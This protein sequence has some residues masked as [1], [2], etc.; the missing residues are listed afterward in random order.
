[1]GKFQHYL[2]VALRSLKKHKVSSALSLLGLSAAFALSVVVGLMTWSA[3]SSDNHWKNADNIYNINRIKINKDGRPMVYAMPN[4]L[5]ED[6]KSF[7]SDIIYATSPFFMQAEL[8][9]ENKYQRLSGYKVDE[10]FFKIF[11]YKII[12]GNIQSIFKVPNGIALSEMKAI[13]L[14]GKQ[15]PIGQSVEL[16]YR[17]EPKLFSIQSIFKKPSGWS[18]MR[19][20]DAFVASPEDVS[21][22]FYAWV[23]IL[24]KE[25]AELENLIPR[26]TKHVEEKYPPKEWEKATHFAKFKL[27]GASFYGVFSW[28]YRERQIGLMISAAT[29][30]LVALLN[31]MALTTA[32]TATRGKDVALRKIMGA[33]RGELS[34]Q[35]VVES[36]LLVSFAYLLG[37]AFAE[38]I[39]G[40]IGALIGNEF[41]VV[42][43]EHGFPLLVGWALAL[44][45]GLLTSTYPI[46]AL[47]RGKASDLLANFQRNL[48][49]GGTRL[50]SLL[51]ILQT[52]CGLGL[53]LGS[54][55]IYLQTNHAEYADKGFEQEGLLYISAPRNQKDM[56]SA[57]PM[58]NALA[59]VEGIKGLSVASSPPPFRGSLWER[60]IV[61]PSTAEHVEIKYG[62]IGDNFMQLLRV[63]I[64]AGRIPPAVESLEKGDEPLSETRILVNEMF[65]EE[66]FPNISNEEVLDRCVFYIGR[67]DKQ[68]DTCNKITAV[69]ANYHQDSGEQALAATIFFPQKSK[70]TN[71]IMVRYDPTQGKNLL[72]KVQA[73]WDEY[74]PF[75]TFNYDFVDDL[76]EKGFIQQRATASLLLFTAIASLVLTVAGLY[77]MAKF[78][79]ARR[80][81]EIA[82]R[83]VLGASSGDIVKLVV[84]QL[85][86]P[87]IVGALI[88][89]PIGWYYAMDWLSAYSIRIE[90]EPWH[91]VLLGIFG[92]AFFLITA[93]GEILRAMR[94]RPA[95]VLHYE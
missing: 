15:D 57:G 55:I 24:E 26:L 13:E 53:V 54:G 46:F 84:M 83:R 8:K 65:V 31:Y 71:Y 25:G 58:K 92:V 29:M 27:V 75:R 85:A 7:S 76:I 18:A 43:R 42:S 48:I 3:I 87:I 72:P 70:Y 78:V 44:G 38:V 93:T 68:E 28:H 19:Y 35:Y 36:L 52:A 74:F 79:V 37:I 1:M 30:L 14:F 20:I 32:V 62:T 88:G 9:I 10:D 23:Y 81:R 41:E 40:Q 33:S 89:L 64:V 50:R 22:E 77:A 39:A 61:H 63:P 17:D 60:K 4:G 6:F 49:A 95:E 16:F 45:V 12:Y 47:V 67:E 82:I 51:L 2:I 5:S 21:K 66:Y 34:A 80:G 90:P 91:A 69:M 94:I 86:K 73:V 56:Q 59:R 11:D